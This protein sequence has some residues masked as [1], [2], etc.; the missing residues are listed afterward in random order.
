MIEK[1]FNDMVVDEFSTVKRVRRKNNLF[2]SKIW[3]FVCFFMIIVGTI[4]TVG[5]VSAE[6]ERIAMENSFNGDTDEEKFA[7]FRKVTVG[8][9]KNGV[10][11][12]SAS[13]VDNTHNR[14]AVA[15]RLASDAGVQY[16]VNLSDNEDDLTKNIS[17]DDF[18]SANYLSLYEAGK[19][20]LLHMDMKFK[21]QKFGEKIV[22]GLVAMVD[23]EGPYLVHCVEGK[24]RTGYAMMVLEALLGASYEEI[25]DDYMETYDNYYGINQESDP[26]RYA[27]IKEKNIDSMLHYIVGDE[28]ADLVAI[29]DYAGYAKDYLKSMGMSEESIEKLVERLSG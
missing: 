29:S 4:G 27:S 25:V 10:L 28:S 12:R 13:P 5:I 19:V 18:D 2:S 17:K 11:F 26:E 21:E 3:F 9:L 14:A 8:K 1:R 16:V 15:D 7:N 20:V 6:R 23:N 24:D 22:R